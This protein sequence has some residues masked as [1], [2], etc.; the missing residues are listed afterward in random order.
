MGNDVSTGNKKSGGSRRG[1]R[2]AFERFV[3]SNHLPKSSVGNLVCH[4]DDD[5]CHQE[6]PSR[7]SD[8]TESCC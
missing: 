4:F 3:P 8:K 5:V 6:V 1:G 2:G 7:A